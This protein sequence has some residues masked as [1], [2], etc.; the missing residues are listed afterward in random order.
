MIEESLS[1][2]KLPIDTDQ[3]TTKN[4]DITKEISSSTNLPIDQEY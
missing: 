1:S 4:T 3:L 2:T